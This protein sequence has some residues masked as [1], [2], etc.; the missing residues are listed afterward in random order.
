MKKSFQVGF[1]GKIEL[2]GADMPERVSHGDMFEITLYFRVLQKPTQ[3]Y[4]ILAHFDGK[5]VRFQ[6]DHDP[7]SGRCGLAEG[8][9]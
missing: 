3:N 7:I 9:G 6:G 4:K 8:S 5:G 2:I 1:D